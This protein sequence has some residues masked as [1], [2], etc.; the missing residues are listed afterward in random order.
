MIG[1]GIYRVSF[2]QNGG[3]VLE[4]NTVENVQ[5][6]TY[7]IDNAP[8]ILRGGIAE[9]VDVAATSSK[10]TTKY[11]G[12]E[13]E[14]DLNGDG[15]DDAAFLLTRTSSGTGTFYYVAAALQ[16]NGGYTGTNA[17]LLG[18]RIIPQTTEIDDGE[19]TVNYFDRRKGEPMTTEPSLAVSRYFHIVAGV[20]T[21]GAHVT[22]VAHTASA[23]CVANKGT[24]SYEFGECTGVSAQVCTKLIG[25]DFHQC[26]SACRHDP[27][28][29]ICTAQCVQV[30][31]VG[32][33]AY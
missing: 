5:D 21:E 28:A 22:P 33:G 27:A 31:E 2:T 14:G 18:D 9:T 26:A 20:L 11:F 19:I 6:G 3:T 4:E 29:Q 1:L 7:T 8:V 25:G 13:A 17:V 16:R 23:Q 15:T 12:N 32:A 10:I 24:W 30:C